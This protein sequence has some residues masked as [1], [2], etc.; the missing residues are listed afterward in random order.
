MEDAPPLAAGNTIDVFAA[1][2]G[3]QQ[4][5]I[6]H[7]LIVNTVSGGSLTLLVPVADEAS[8][9]AVGSSNVALHVAF[10]TPGAQ[11]APS[12]LS[13]DAAIHLLCGTA[14]GG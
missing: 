12:P 9:I 2:T 10:T 11:L 8:W 1:L 4:V 6:G 14:C 3:D 13:A 5:L 7:D